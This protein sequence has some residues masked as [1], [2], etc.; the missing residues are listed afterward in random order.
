[1]KNEDNKIIIA[2]K[3]KRKKPENCPS[4]FGL[5]ITERLN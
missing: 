1:V 5:Y 4:I 3:K 2:A